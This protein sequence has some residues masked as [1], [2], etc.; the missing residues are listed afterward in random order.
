M[1]TSLPH[2]GEYGPIGTRILYENDLVRV[3]E[4]L[5]E[6][7]EEQGMHQHTLPYVVIAVEHGMNQITSIDGDVRKTEETPGHI[8]FQAPGQIHNL[9]NIG[10]TRY[11][12]RL[13]EIKQPY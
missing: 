11:R 13:V 6:P 2:V 1:D 3:W 4:V 9:K 5:L 7:G 12:N 10:T 8:V